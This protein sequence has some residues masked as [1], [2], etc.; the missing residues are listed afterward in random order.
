MRGSSTS[1]PSP[2]AA[3]R[4]ATDGCR[5]RC[6]PSR[7]SSPSSPAHTDWFPQG[8]GERLSPLGVKTH[9]PYAPSVDA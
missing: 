5:I 4:P 9:L 8:T 1:T 3:C 2:C 7:I 6:T